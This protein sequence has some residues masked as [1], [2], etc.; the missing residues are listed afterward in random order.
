MWGKHEIASPYSVAWHCTFSRRSETNFQEADRH[1]KEVFLQ[2][3][4]LSQLLQ[5]G[6]CSRKALEEGEVD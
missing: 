2:F 5:I 3:G 6:E 4:D 1:R